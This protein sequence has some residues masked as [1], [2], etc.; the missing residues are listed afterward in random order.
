LEKIINLFDLTPEQKDFLESLTKIKW[1]RVQKKVRLGL[2]RQ[3][4]DFEVAPN[5]TLIADGFI[6]HNSAAA[7]RRLR[8]QSLEDLKELLGHKNIQTTTIY[9]ALKS[10]ELKQRI[11]RVL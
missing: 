8:G 1:L 2:V 10:Q 11:K 7:L 6:T 5:H 4:Y 9:S 3:V